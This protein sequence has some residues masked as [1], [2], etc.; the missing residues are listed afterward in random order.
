MATEIK[1]EPFSPKEILTMMRK[2]GKQI[3]F[4]ESLAIN[5][6]GLKVQAFEVK[7]M[8]RV[9]RIRSKWAKPKGKFGINMK[10][11]NKR[12]LTA[13]VF[14]R[15][16]WLKKQEDGGVKK[17][18]VK[19]PLVGKTKL[20]LPVKEIRKNKT[21]LI[22]KKFS[23][24]KL[25]KDPKKNRV[26]FVDT[27]GGGLILQR[28]GRKKNAKTRVLFFVE[29]QARIKPVLKFEETGEKIVQKVYRRE[30]GVALKKAI[31]S[32]K[33]NIKEDRI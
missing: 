30:F 9:F 3:P 23:P 24:A 16:P 6:T 19:T 21:R 5:S 15:A 25:L 2:F 20:L 28:K 1:V 29:D 13:S 11:S 18:H 27:P 8:P 31:R 12:N 22:Q 14:S 26:F 4:A 17:G 10:F 7:R 33:G 32:A